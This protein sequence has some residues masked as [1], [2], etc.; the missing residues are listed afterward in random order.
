M[1]AIFFLLLLLNRSQPPQ[2]AVVNFF[3]AG[4]LFTNKY[5]VRKI[6]FF[7]GNF[8]YFVVNLRN[9]WCTFIGLNNAV[10]FQYGQI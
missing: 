3:Q 9:F 8:G 6:L 2:P 1:E 5:R 4:V 10:V 7:L